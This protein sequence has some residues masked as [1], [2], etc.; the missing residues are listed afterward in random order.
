MGKSQY[1]VFIGRFQPFHRGHLEVM[2]NALEDEAEKL[3]VVVGSHRTPRSLKNPW[4]YEERVSMIMPSMPRDWLDRVKIVPAR[5][6]MYDNTMWLTGIQNVVTRAIGPS[7]QTVTK[8]IGHFK[9]D[10]SFYLRLF[11]QWKLVAEPNHFGVNSTKIREQLYEDGS[12]NPHLVP[13]AVMKYMLRWSKS[14]ECADLRNEWRF[15]KEYKEKWASAPFPP[16]FVTTDAVVVQAGHVLLVR[17]K[18]NPG[19]GKYALPGGFLQRDKQILDSCVAE[20][21]EETNMMFPREDLIK[22]LRE[23]HVFDHPSRD[24]R[25]RTI[26]HAHYFEIDRLGPLPSVEGGDDADEALW[27]PLSDLTLVEEEFFSDH[28]HIINYFVNGVGR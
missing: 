16:V 13:S 22:C 27:L 23:V 11:P 6:Y 1:C 10:S 3:I 19:K 24:Q 21:K 8:L 5:D 28:I 25:G 2:K 18:M 9:D 20:V 15:L 17:R 7:Q 14:D 12:M 26:T 4:S